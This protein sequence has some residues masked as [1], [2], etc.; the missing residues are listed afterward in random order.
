MAGQFNTIRDEATGRLRPTTEEE[1][2]H[3]MQ[4]A[5]VLPPD[6]PGN[7]TDRDVDFVQ[8]FRESEAE[9]PELPQAEP[10]PPPQAKSPSVSPALP[11]AT[12]PA[13]VAQGG[14]DLSGI[15]QGASVGGRFAGPVGALLGAGAGFVAGGQRSKPIGTPG[16][17]A[18]MQQDETQNTLRQLLA[19]QQGIAKHGSP[20][21]DEIRTQAVGSRM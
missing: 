17:Q 21:K 8:R 13:D 15:A 12:T 16:G 2:Q 1:K 7:L 9:P 14:A 18:A 19:V 4:K 3:F 5:G 11:P 10:S 20:I 6:L